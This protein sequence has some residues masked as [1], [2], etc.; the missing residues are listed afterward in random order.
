MG[1]CKGL[2]NMEKYLIPLITVVFGIA[3]L[4]FIIF[5]SIEISDVFDKAKLVVDKLKK[6]Q[7]ELDEC[8]GVIR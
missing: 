2:G 8:R 1:R 5:I 3:S 7:Q 4:V 6:T